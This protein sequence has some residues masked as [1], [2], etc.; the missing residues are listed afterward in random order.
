MADEAT[1]TG[2]D[3]QNNPGEFESF[4]QFLEKQPESVQKL[5]E[6][7]TSGLKSALQKER[8]SKKD[9][10]DQLKAATAKAEKGSDLEKTLLELQKQSAASER[11]ARFAEE[12]ITP[13]IGCTNVKAAFALAVAEDL[14]KKSGD[15]DW[16]AIKKAAPELFK[17]PGSTTSG[18]AGDG[19]GEDGKPKRSM[20]DLLRA[21]R[22][23]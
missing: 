6:T 5:Y 13:E 22:S 20:N 19:T 7:H 15:P 14:F 23:R 11:R 16:E 17:K 2:G 9:L 8:D 4:E 10:D 21:A 12:A 18:K 1:K 3:P